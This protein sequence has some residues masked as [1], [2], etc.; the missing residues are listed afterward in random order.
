MFKRSLAAVA[1]VWVLAT[2]LSPV[3]SHAQTPPDSLTLQPP[4]NVFVVPV[5]NPNRARFVNYIFWEGIDP[6][7]GT[8][9][10]PPDTLGWHPPGS[11]TPKGSLS[12]PSTTGPYLGDVDRT[13]S[14]R[15]LNSGIVGTTPGIILRYDIVGQEEFSKTLDPGA[16]YTPGDPIPI[17]VINTDAIPPDTLDLGFTVHFSAGLIDSNGIFI[18]GL[19]TFEGYHSWRG[20]N[21]D[22]SDLIVLSEMSNEERFTA[23]PFDSIYFDEIIPALRATGVFRL[24]FPVPGLGSEIDIRNIHPN[25]KLGPNEFTWFDLNAFHGFTYH[26]LVTTFDRGY[27]VRAARQGLI[28][29]DNCQPT[30][31]VPVPCRGELV[32]VTTKVTP[33]NSLIEIYAVPN[34]Y[35]SGSSQ[36]STPNY[37]NFPDNT[38][39]FVNVPAN[40]KL[41]IYTSAGDIVW[42][43]DNVNGPGVIEW[44]TRNAA[45]EEVSSGAYLYRIQTPDGEGMF[46]R[47]VIIR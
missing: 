25:G 16:G 4:T 26:Y 32:S 43:T 40:C 31:G 23:E 6:T 45:G 44:D 39:R 14:F 2:V 7:I 42:W 24:P 22:G 15:A 29:F 20:L 37:H 3:R 33:Q 35:R 41:H 10:H 47:L 18:V 8:L 11:T 28:K 34:P 19:E 36:F 5:M 46:G 27:E 9:V 17:S 30:N 38:L 21:A 1:L 12:L 13:V